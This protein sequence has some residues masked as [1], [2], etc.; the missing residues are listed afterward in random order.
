MKRSRLASD[1]YGVED[2][3]A[4]FE[5]A[6]NLRT[7]S[8]AP[9]SPKAQSHSDSST[10]KSKA[11]APPSDSNI[12]KSGIKCIC[13]AIT[14]KPAQIHALMRTLWINGERPGRIYR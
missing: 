6:L 4:L 1:S 8:D 7:S 3:D 5:E 14:N 9:S 13:G 11:A 2:T 10:L 12:P